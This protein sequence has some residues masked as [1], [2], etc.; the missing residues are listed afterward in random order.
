ML[1]RTELA[2]MPSTYR[3]RHPALRWIEKRLPIGRLLDGDN[4]HLA[5]TSFRP[6]IEVSQGVLAERAGFEPAIRFPVYTLSKRA[7]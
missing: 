7:P 1:S 3:P 2:D 6:K 5:K 4:L